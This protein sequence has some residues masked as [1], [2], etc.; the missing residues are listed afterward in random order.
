M[1]IRKVGAVSVVIFSNQRDRRAP[2]E[3]GIES[4]QHQG[5][6]EQ[7]CVGGEGWESRKEDAAAWERRT[8]TKDL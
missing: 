8:N 6:M 5:G 7:D 1:G 2:R 3:K 4:R